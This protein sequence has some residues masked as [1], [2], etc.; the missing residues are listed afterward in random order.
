MLSSD[1]HRSGLAP[2][3]GVGCTHTSIVARLY[4]IGVVLFFSFFVF[5]FGRG[6][7]PVGNITACNLA[8]GILGGRGVGGRRWGGRSL[9]LQGLPTRCHLL[10]GAT[11]ERG[12]K[13]SAADL[14]VISDSSS[15]VLL[16]SDWSLLSLPERVRASVR[17]RARVCMRD[18]V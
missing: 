13:S 12:W 8:E 9:Q 10:G 16:H 18:S 15:P 6:T 14:H 1:G 3:Q 11:E 2:S 5:F 17:A 7:E 4:R